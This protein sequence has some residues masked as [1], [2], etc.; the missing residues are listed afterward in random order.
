[1]IAQY[2]AA[3]LV[4]ENKIL[5]SPAVVDSIPTSGNQEDHVS[6]GTIAARK[7]RQI[8][9]NV[10]NVL[11]IE[12][13]CAAQGIDFLAPLEPGAG[14]RAAHEAVRAQVPHLDH[15]RVLAPDIALIRELIQG[16]ALLRAVE[17][18]VG[19]LE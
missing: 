4:S 3:A 2:T 9:A 15:D 5:A 6:M 10:A 14:A 19:Q 16:E 13:M 17:H 18:A 1:M 12:V 7:A 11:S 8:A